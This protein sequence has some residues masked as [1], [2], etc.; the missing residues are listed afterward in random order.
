MTRQFNDLFLIS[1]AF[2]YKM[3]FHQYNIVCELYSGLVCI[4][5]RAVATCFLEPTRKPGVGIWRRA[6]HRGQ[7]E[8]TGQSR[9]SGQSG[10]CP[11]KTLQNE[12]LWAMQ[13]KMTKI[14]K[15]EQTT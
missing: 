3:S 2:R 4:V 5:R 8:R 11:G 14:K 15:R 9:Q 12:F 7:K 10:Q 6:G 13:R 1:R